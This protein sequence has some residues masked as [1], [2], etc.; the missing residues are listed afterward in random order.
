MLKRL[1]ATSLIALAAPLNA[2]A[3]QPA[4]MQGTVEDV[5]ATE[6]NAADHRAIVELS[7][8]FDNT[9]DEGDI[10]AHMSV[11]ADDMRFESPFGTFDAKEDY[12]A[13]VEEFHR[14]A[15]AYGGTRHLVTNNVIGVDGDRATQTCYQVILGRTEDDGAPKM[16][17]SARMED[18]LVRTPDGWRFARRVL[19]LDQDPTRFTGD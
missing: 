16:L 7:N 1:V 14:S 19:H 18:E 9:I 11:W 17:A 6:A 8:F 13:W 2:Q 4:P 15:Q 3:T 10:D 5:G 12:R